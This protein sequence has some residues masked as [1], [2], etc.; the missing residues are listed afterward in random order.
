MAGYGMVGSILYDY[1][2]KLVDT[3]YSTVDVM[4]NEY[5]VVDVM[6]TVWFVI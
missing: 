3:R 2:L 5:S 1:V 6:M 4:V